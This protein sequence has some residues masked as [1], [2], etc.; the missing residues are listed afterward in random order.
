MRALLLLPLI[1]LLVMIAVGSWIGFWNC[2]LWLIA[3]AL[4]GIWL[5]KQQK[6]TGL[7]Q[8]KSQLAF[9]L[10]SSGNMAERLLL[11]VAGLLLLFPGFVSDLMALVLLL[12]PVRAWLLA[13]L[14]S[15]FSMFAAGGQ[16]FDV[17]P[18]PSAD[19]KGPGNLLEGEYQRKD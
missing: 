1:E 10:M 14:L 17:K 16:I 15:K 6:L 11:A 5:L 12:P 8:M 13:R 4:L 2:L 19:A 9:N 18:S 3:S 7:R